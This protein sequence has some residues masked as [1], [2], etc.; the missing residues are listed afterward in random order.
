MTMLAGWAHC[1]TIGSDEFGE[2]IYISV[3]RPLVS[4]SVAMWFS[5]NV[6]NVFKKNKPW[7]SP[8]PFVIL[9]KYAHTV[10]C[11]SEGYNASYVDDN[12]GWMSSPSLEKKY[13]IIEP[14][15]F[16]IIRIFAKIKHVQHNVWLKITI[17][18]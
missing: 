5:G 10:Q 11:V 15:G 6:G 2:V 12:T 7:P 3:P 13:L 9:L 17:G 8:K 18:P 4:V 16:L 1:L 14:G